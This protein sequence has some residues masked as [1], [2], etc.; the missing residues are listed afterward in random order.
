ME[1]HWS[2]EA[3]RAHWV[4]SSGELELLKE[5][6]ARRGLVVANCNHNWFGLQTARFFDRIN[7]DYRGVKT[8]PPFH[9]EVRHLMSH[10]KRLNS[11]DITLRPRNDGSSNAEK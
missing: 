4:L 10:I 7:C 5:M 6:L 1:Q 9:S 2:A 3:L 8:E 11:R